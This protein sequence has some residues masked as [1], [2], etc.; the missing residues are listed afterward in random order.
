MRILI[1]LTYYE[2]NTSGLTIYAV[3]EARALAALGHEVTV[4]TSQFE[5]DLPLEETDH[6]VRIVRVPVA[7]HLSKGVVMP[8]LPGIAWRLLREADVVNLHLP[9]LDSAL[10]SLFAR[11][12]H[13][14]VVLTYHCFLDMPR[15]LISRL[16]GWPFAS[17]IG[18]PSSWVT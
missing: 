16:A 18:F 2:P 3:R 14:P 9:Q 10:I 12:Q 7:F 17:P 13:K 1:G 5:P 15:G 11:W 8:R 4:L 6:G